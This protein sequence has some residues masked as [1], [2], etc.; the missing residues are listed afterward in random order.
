MGEQ[1]LAASR[2][3]IIV[4]QKDNKA[5]ALFY[6]DLP[7]INVNISDGF[8]HCLPLTAVEFKEL[9]TKVEIPDETDIQNELSRGG[10]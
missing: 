5:A 3:L 6:N 4:R 8:A 7:N 9:W 2:E 1:D 10:D